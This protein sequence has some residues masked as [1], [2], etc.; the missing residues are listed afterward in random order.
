MDVRIFRT[1]YFKPQWNYSQNFEYKYFKLGV[2]LVSVSQFDY[3][4]PLQVHYK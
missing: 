2:L 1:L 4:G 3:L